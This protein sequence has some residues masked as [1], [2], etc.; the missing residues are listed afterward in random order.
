VPVDVHRGSETWTA[1]STSVSVFTRGTQCVARPAE[2]GEIAQVRGLRGIR[3]GDQ[4]GSPSGAPPHLFA[5][6][7]LETVVSAPGHELEL[8]EALTQLA[9]QD[10]LINVRAADEIVVSLYGEVQKEVLQATLL[11]DYGLRVTFEASSIVCVESLVGVGESV[12]EMGEDNP[13]VATIGFR[14]SPG[15]PGYGLEV[16]LGCLPLAFHKAIEETV[17]ATLLSG[18][19][20]WEVVNAVVTLTHAGFSSPVSVAADFRKLTPLVLMAAIRQAGTVVLEPV[21]TFDLEIPVDTTSAVVAAL[22]H[23]DAYPESVTVQGETCVLEGVIPLRA[24][25]ALRQSLPGLTH[26]DGAMV[27]SFHSHQRRG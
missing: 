3:I 14:V 4:L 25:P 12:T 7:S 20:G 15:K 11:D 27:T 2:T 24:V 19:H 13:F 8:H 23:H 21:D 18:P 22:S 9:D 26:G 5:P 1:R 10:P 6:P 17:H 16:E